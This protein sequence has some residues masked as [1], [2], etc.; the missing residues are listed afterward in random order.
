MHTQ[1]WGRRGAGTSKANVFLQEPEGVEQRRSA[2][3]LWQEPGHL[4]D[5]RCRHK[6]VDWSFWFSCYHWRLSVLL[7]GPASTRHSELSILLRHQ[8]M[9][10]KSRLAS[11]FT[12]QRVLCIVNRSI[13]VDFTM[14]KSM[15]RMEIGWSGD[16]TLLQ[17]RER[18]KAMNI[19]V[20]ACEQDSLSLFVSP[21]WD[22]M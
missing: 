10:F 21:Q 14:M 15:I 22:P 1:V 9:P 4:A 5:S 20:K 19:P 8:N 7:R 11:L 12:L 13:C 2:E 16:V 3:L 6:A 17:Q 18:N